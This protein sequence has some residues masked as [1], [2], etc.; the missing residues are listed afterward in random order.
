MFSVSKI[1]VSRRRRTET[2]HESCTA[3]HTVGAAE[4]LKR[5]IA[6]LEEEL[7]EMKLALQRKDGEL[8]EAQ[9]DLSR[10]EVIR[11]ENTENI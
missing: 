7:F 1:P 9:A 4:E 10:D 3:T 8:Q 6:S 5:N 11:A 2:R